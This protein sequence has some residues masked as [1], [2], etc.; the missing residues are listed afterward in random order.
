[1]ELG[2]EEFIHCRIVRGDWFWVGHYH[3]VIC[4]MFGVRLVSLKH[5]LNKEDKVD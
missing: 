2:R 5:L 3:K 1:M 4:G